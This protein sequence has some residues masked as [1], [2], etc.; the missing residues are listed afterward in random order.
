LAFRDTFSYL[1]VQSTKSHQD[2]NIL[3]IVFFQINEQN[4]LFLA[5]KASFYEKLNE[6]SD[7]PKDLFEKDKEGDLNLQTRAFGDIN[8]DESEW[9]T[10]PDLER[11]YQSRQAVPASYDA[12]ASGK[13]TNP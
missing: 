13:N 6:L 10:H 1:C 7:M 12:T 4:K 5:G 3:I 8:I 9:Y 11:L 2:A